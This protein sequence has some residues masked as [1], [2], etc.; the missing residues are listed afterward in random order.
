[1][2]AAAIP[3]SK[4]YARL[5]GLHARRQCRLSDILFSP[6]PALVHCWRLYISRRLTWC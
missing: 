1:M 5:Q 3:D 2:T 4:D 6:I